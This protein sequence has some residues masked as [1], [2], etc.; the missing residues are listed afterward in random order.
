MKNDIIV[1]IIAVLL[2]LFLVVLFISWV[3]LGKFV[4]GLF[5]SMRASKLTASDIMEIKT[6]GLLH[7]TNAKGAD[8]IL[9]SM[10]VKGRSGPVSYSNRF[11]KSSFFF[12]SSYLDTNS[13]KFNFAFR[14]SKIVKINNITDEQ[15]EKMKIRKHDKALIVCGDFHILDENTVEVIPIYETKRNKIKSAFFSFIYGCKFLHWQI[16]S[17][18]ISAIPVVCI[19]VVVW[20]LI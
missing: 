7:K 6:G 14:H 19:M 8:G 15:I 17:L 13:E 20:E 10:V 5:P 16:L 2:I 1:L 12:I 3:V 11:R 18:C 9:K 4:Y